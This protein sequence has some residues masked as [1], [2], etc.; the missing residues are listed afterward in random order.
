MDVTFGSGKLDLRN[1]GILKDV[2]IYINTAFSGINIKLPQG[3][4]VEL[5]TSTSFGGV[6][7]K[8]I[9]STNM[10]AP[11]VHIFAAVSFAG[12]EIK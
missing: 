6:S 5:Q 7:N 12:V 2:T 1:A 3:C 9:S 11:T 8:Y 4:K 10:N